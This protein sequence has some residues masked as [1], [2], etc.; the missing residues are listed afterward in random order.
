MAMHQEEQKT[1]NKRKKAVRV[2]HEAIEKADTIH[3]M[4]VQ[5]KEVDFDENLTVLG[6]EGDDDQPKQDDTAAE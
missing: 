4:V 3:R 1:R 5:G 6:D 2:L